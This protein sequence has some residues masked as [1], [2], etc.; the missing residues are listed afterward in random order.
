MVRSNRRLQVGLVGGPKSTLR[1]L[2][3]YVI[4]KSGCGAVG[5][6]LRSGRRGREFESHHPDHFAIYAAN[7]V[8]RQRSPMNGGEIISL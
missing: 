5:S 8:S 3:R 2:H 4:P 6:A 7:R 1:R